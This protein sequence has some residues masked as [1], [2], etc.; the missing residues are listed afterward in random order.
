M[1]CHFVRHASG[2]HPVPSTSA[3]QQFCAYVQFLTLNARHFAL[4]MRDIFLT[5]P[6]RKISGFTHLRIGPFR[7]YKGKRADPCG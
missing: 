3:N 7:S 4:Q 5:A 6:V 2:Q 1:N